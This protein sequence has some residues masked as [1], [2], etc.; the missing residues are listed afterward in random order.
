MRHL[1][2]TN[3]RNEKSESVGGF[4]IMYLRAQ[5]FNRRG[6]VDKLVIHTEQDLTR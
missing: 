2:P 5:G 6:Q 3:Y 1:E 4:Y